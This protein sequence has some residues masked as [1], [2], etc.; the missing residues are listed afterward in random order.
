[1]TMQWWNKR[2]RKLPRWAWIGVASVAA[3]FSLA[4]YFHTELDRWAGRQV[5]ALLDDGRVRV[6]PS[7][8]TTRILSP[9]RSDGY[10]DYVAALDQRASAGV[11]PADN[12]AVLFWRA[13]GPRELGTKMRSEFFRRLG[14]GELPDDGEYLST[15]LDYIRKSVPGAQQ[16]A[17]FA[18]EKQEIAII[19]KRPWT[20]KE[21]P[22]AA[23][24]LGANEGPLRLLIEASHRSRRYDPLISPFDGSVMGILLPYLP[25]HRR[26]ARALAWR[27]M[28]RIGERNLEGAWEDV[29]ACHRLA[30]LA[31]HGELVLDA[32]IAAAINDLAF[33]AEKQILA[34]GISAEFAAVIQRELNS[35]AP[36]PALADRFDIGERFMLL[37]FLNLS[38]RQGIS[39]LE[40]GQDWQQRKGLG[41]SWSDALIKVRTDWN[42]VLRR[43][44]VRFDRLAA[45]CR[46][47][48]REQRVEALAQ[49]VAEMDRITRQ[50]A[51]SPFIH[52]GNPSYVTDRIDQLATALLITPVPRLAN[53]EYRTAAQ[54]DLV[55]VACALACFHAEHGRYP[56]ILEELVPEHLGQV[57]LDPFADG[58]FDYSP[59]AAGYRLAS[60]GYQEEDDNNIRVVTDDGVDDFVIRVA[61]DEGR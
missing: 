3:T 11:N 43:G 12:S 61:P 44:N 13:M 9:L 56:A 15:F 38:A 19:A 24:W 6:T 35:L 50:S 51:Q 26:A 33:R 32:M 53:M 48:K 7:E 45:I 30:A 29:L 4:C 60:V 39:G 55:R 34:T 22:L 8:E 52:H 37:D 54:R 21:C 41:D 20:A 17:A 2:Q 10:V 27:A 5:T 58:P 57:P 46:L 59:E 31:G 14:T 42:E 36:P 47:P 25:E 18:A 16:P 28:L 23:Q 1:M 40:K 49:F